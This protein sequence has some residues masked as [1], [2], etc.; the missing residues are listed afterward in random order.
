MFGKV[1]GFENG[2]LC[3]GSGCHTVFV[4]THIKP[5]HVWIKICSEGEQVC[6]SCSV[7]KVG[8][9]LSND[10]I[11]FCVEVNTSKCE[12]EWFCITH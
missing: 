6:G 10:G 11:T 7:D 5:H 1:L 2:N 9:I 8:Y 12:I 4:P 3:L